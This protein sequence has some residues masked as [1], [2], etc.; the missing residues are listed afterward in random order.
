MAKETLPAI[1]E[2][3]GVVT[4]SKQPEFLQMMEEAGLDQK[5]RDLVVSNLE[6]VGIKHK[7]RS[8]FICCGNDCISAHI[9]PFIAEKQTALLP[10]GK[11]CPIDMVI[12]QSYYNNILH[13]MQEN[14]IEHNATSETL[15]REL[16]SIEIYVSRIDDYL[17]KSLIDMSDAQMRAP[18]TYGE[19]V[20]VNM[21]TGEVRYKMVEHPL[22]KTRAGLEDRRAKILQRLLLTPEIRTK[23]KISTADSLSKLM[24]QQRKNAQEAIKNAKQ[25]GSITIEEIQ[26][27]AEARMQSEKPQHNEGV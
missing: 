4:L 25:H 26:K 5:Q 2:E 9:C 3:R 23:M 27:R 11:P 12:G 16:V 7:S 19:P 10:I 13:D 22:V 21:K 24:E 14:Q 20:P 18:L 8:G 15:L 1:R 6:D 17:S